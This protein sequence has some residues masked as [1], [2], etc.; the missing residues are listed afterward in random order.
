MALSASLSANEKYA[1]NITGSNRDAMTT[2]TELPTETTERAMS[3]TSSSDWLGFDDS[4]SGSK[5][6]VATLT[7]VVNVVRT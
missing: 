1:Q 3:S 4:D 5:S 7:N 6:I 2:V